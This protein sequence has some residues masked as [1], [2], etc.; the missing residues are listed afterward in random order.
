M[1]QAKA[2]STVGEVTRRSPA[3]LFLHAAQGTGVFAILDEECAGGPSSGSGLA[4]RSSLADCSA[5]AAPKRLTLLLGGSPGLRP[6]LQ[7]QADQATS[8]RRPQSPPSL[9]FADLPRG[10]RRFDEIK[11]KP[12]WLLGFSRRFG[13]GLGAYFVPL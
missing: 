10:H 11:T 12:S 6:G 9:I 1:L 5:A 8:R 3:A 13:L 2:R 4:G 7:Q